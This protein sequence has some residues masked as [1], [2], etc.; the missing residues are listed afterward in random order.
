MK[1]IVLLIVLL[2]T[3]FMVSSSFAYEF[4]SPKK[5]EGPVQIAERIGVSPKKFIALNLRLG[6]FKY[7]NRVSLIY[8]GQKFAVPPLSAK[9]VAS[10]IKVKEAGGMVKIGNPVK[11]KQV[12]KQ[13]IS[14]VEKVEK[15]EGRN[16]KPD[17]ELEGKIN[18]IVSFV[19]GVQERIKKDVS[20]LRPEDYKK[21]KWII[22]TVVS[23]VCLFFITLKITRRKASG[24]LN[25]ANNIH[26]SLLEFLRHKKRKLKRAIPGRWPLSGGSAREPVFICCCLET[27][28]FLAIHGASSY[29]TEHGGKRGLEEILNF[30]ET[31]YGEEGKELIKF[32]VPQSCADSYRTLTLKERSIG[33]FKIR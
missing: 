32:E 6:N 25:Y 4:A 24:F 22:W 20:V 9:S 29:Q 11:S 10:G 13:K 30:I 12:Q 14:E 3:F 2:V 17:P 33:D 16:W 26:S 18:E 28:N 19:A 15:D 8:M 7:P 1:R 31:V 5:G 23:F 27:G 21:K